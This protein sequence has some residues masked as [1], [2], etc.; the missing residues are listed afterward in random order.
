VCREKENEERE[1]KDAVR[2]IARTMR[3]RV[4]AV[5]YARAALRVI[6][7]PREDTKFTLVEE[8]EEEEKSNRAQTTNDTKK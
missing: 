8:Q 3:A 6:D 4:S 1:K 2:T 5:I 7:S